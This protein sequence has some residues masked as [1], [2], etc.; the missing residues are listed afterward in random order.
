M[1]KRTKKGSA[2]SIME[3]YANYGH[4][5]K[6]YMERLAWLYQ[7]ENYTK[8]DLE[9]LLT[10]V[11]ELKNV[12]WNEVHYIFYMDPEGAP[13]PR[14]NPK[15]FV[16]YV[17]GASYNHKIFEA[18]AEAHSNMECVI[19]TPCIMETRTYTKIPKGMHKLEKMAAELELIHN[20]NAPDW[21]NLGKSYC[22][23]V[24]EVVVSND[25]IVVRGAV[26][27]FYSVLPR[28]EVDVK[29]MTKYDCAYNKRTVENRKSF[30]LNPK[31]IKDLPYIIGGRRK[32]KNG[33][34]I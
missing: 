6:D 17:S 8:E 4:I 33:N 2:K 14:R 19:S 16:F 27:K 12:D 15:T 11:E 3:Y 21:D 22:D 10:M 1:A 31:T 9:D 29:F 20:V 26:E 5:P 28:I 34:T 24:Q 32:K 13:R 18:F 30:K 23:M 25:S 7:E